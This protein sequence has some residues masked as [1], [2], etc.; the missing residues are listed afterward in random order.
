MEAGTKVNGLCVS[1][2]IVYL[3]LKV[4]TIYWLMEFSSK[5]NVLVFS[6]SI[7]FFP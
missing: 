5:G 1:H 2:L 4:N 3:L 7:N 6:V